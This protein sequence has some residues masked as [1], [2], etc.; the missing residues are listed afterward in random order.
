M[1]AGRG[2]NHDCTVVIAQPHWPLTSGHFSVLWSGCFDSVGR[3]LGKCHKRVFFF[4]FFA[5]AGTLRKLLF[6]AVR[7]RNRQFFF[8]L[9]GSLVRVVPPNP[10]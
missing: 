5:I 1:S 9:A 8:V 7:E 2:P 10:S 4:F 3:F 6:S